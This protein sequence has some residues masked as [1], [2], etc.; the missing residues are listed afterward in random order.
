MKKIYEIRRLRY[1][2][3]GHGGLDVSYEHVEN[4]HGTKEQVDHCLSVMNREIDIKKE[5][6]EYYVAKELVIIELH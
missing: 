6:A 5:Y 1:V 2:S 3:N 4:V